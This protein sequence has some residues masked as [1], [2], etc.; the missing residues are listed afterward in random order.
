[1]CRFTGGFLMSFECQWNPIIRGAL[2]LLGLFTA[3]WPTLFRRAAA[4]WAIAAMTYL[5]FLWQIQYLLQAYP[6]IQPA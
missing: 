6:Q 1:M 5:L 4:F 3:S 2:Q